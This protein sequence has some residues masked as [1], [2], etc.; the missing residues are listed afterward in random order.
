[1]DLH[2]HCF[3]CRFERRVRRIDNESVDEVAIVRKTCRSQFMPG[4]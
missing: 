2:T 3:D 1:M 4:R